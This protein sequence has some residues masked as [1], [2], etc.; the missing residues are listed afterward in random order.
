V[1]G[2]IIRPF[3][4]IISSIYN[5]EKDITFDRDVIRH[6]VAVTDLSLKIAIKMG[7]SN[8]DLEDIL[9]AGLLHDIGKRKVPQELRD[10]PKN[11][12]NN[13]EWEQ[14]QQHVLHS[15]VLAEKIL[16][17]CFDC[18]CSDRAYSILNGIFYH[19]ERCDGNGYPTRLIKQEIPLISLIIAVPDVY[20]ALTNPRPYRDW[21]KTKEEALECIEGE[22]QK[23]D[24]KILKIFLEVIN[25]K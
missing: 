10:R 14:V 25:G 19:H 16:F 21:V 24:E 2:N 4:H 20:D 17:E 9:F 8:I 1:K 6:S 23:Y 3:I 15:D 11:T 18:F 7:L 12:M 22:K 5:I 13:E